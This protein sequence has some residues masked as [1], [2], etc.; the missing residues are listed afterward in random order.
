MLDLY[1][2]NKY[3]LNLH[4]YATYPLAKW[5]DWL[6]FNILLLFGGPPNDGKTSEGETCGLSELRGPWWHCW[7]IFRRLKQ[8]RRTHS[9]TH[10]KT[11]SGGSTRISTCHF[12]ALS[13]FKQDHAFNN[14]GV[15]TWSHHVIYIFVLLLHIKNNTLKIFILSYNS[16]IYFS[17]E[18][19][20][21]V[22]VLLCNPYNL[23]QK[24]GS[25]HSIL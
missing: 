2:S 1:Y 22:L 6:V 21:Q 19:L 4:I 9:F 17:G 14:V 10:H 25:L 5:T 7:I 16:Y 8:F 13:L 18:H 11:P 12:R 24:F 15:C 20:V 3:Y 23:T